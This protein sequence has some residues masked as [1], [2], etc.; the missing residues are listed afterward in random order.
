[1]AMKLVHVMFWVGVLL[2]RGQ[3]ER[4]IDGIPRLGQLSTW[5]QLPSI[6][7]LGSPLLT[8]F[9]F[10]PSLLYS[11]PIVCYIT[12]YERLHYYLNYCKCGGIYLML[13]FRILYEF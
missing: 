4:E 1:M 9:V 11:L 3:V 2:K 13:I 7:L 10:Q 5:I 8:P 6:Y 12:Y